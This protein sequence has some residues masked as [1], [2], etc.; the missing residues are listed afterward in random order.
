MRIEIAKISEEGDKYEGEEP[1]E[2][3]ELEKDKF[4][5]P[6][7]SIHYDLFVQRVS[8]QLVVKGIL[9]VKFYLLCSR[10]AEFFSTTVVDSSFLRAY[11]LE[12]GTEVVDVTRD[13]REAVLLKIPPYPVCSAECHGLCRQCGMNLNKGICSCVPP[14]GPSPWDDLNRLKI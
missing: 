14:E 11:K 1:R 12:E 9:Q 4:I 6:S 3:L 2:V 5:D 7:G 13:M 8:D 10:C